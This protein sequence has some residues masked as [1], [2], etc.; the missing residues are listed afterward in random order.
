MAKRRTG[1]EDE[2]YDFATSMLS[3]NEE[4]SGGTS[5]DPNSS[6]SGEHKGDLEK[7]LKEIATLTAKIND[8]EIKM[9]NVVSAVMSV[10][11]VLDVMTVVSSTSTPEFHKV[12]KT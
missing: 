10:K 11:A 9:D 2:M 12:R 8:M 3:S 5:S 6:H 4:Q 1:D 7:V